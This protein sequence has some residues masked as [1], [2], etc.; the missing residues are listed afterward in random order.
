MIY[1]LPLEKDIH[2]SDS[3]IPFQHNFIDFLMTNIRNLFA[4]WTGLL[5]GLNLCAQNTPFDSIPFELGTDHRVYVSC[6]V[7]GS[8]P[9]RFLFDTGATDL[10]MNPN[11]P[12][13]VY[14]VTFDGV[15]D[16]TGATGSNR[17]AKS[18]RNRLEIGHRTLEN[19]SLISIPYPPEYWDGVIGLSFIARQ[20]TEIDYKKRKIYLYDADHYIPSRQAI[21][22]K[23]KFVMGVPVVPVRLVING[24]EYDTKLEIDTGSDRVIDLNTPFVKRHRL[25]GTQQPFALSRIT[26]SDTCGGVLENVYFDEVRLG[27][28]PFVRIPGAFSTVVSGVQSSFEM[29]GVIG[30]NFLKR[31]NIVCDF[32]HGLVY[33]SPNDLLYSP[34]YD[35]LVH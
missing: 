11:S 22:L 9:L 14:P 23:V 2:L 27:D 18:S 5:L 19:I 25:L 34:F 20:V 33:L 35:F 32:A 7:N 29:D 13:S 28:Y 17:V 8:E 6:R 3:V 24:K 30:N 16:N 21:K 12:R 4:V 15:V 31:F 10:V 26:S 1:E